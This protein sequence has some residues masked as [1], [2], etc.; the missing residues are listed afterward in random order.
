M[1]TCSKE[2]F[3]K[4]S[5]NSFRRLT[6]VE[7][8]REVKLTQKNFI[9]IPDVV[10]RKTGTSTK[11]EMLYIY[12]LILKHKNCNMEIVNTPILYISNYNIIKL[13]K[14]LIGKSKSTLRGYLKMTRVMIEHLRIKESSILTVEA[15]KIPKKSDPL[16]SYMLIIY[17]DEN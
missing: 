4:L 10:S 2:D 8:S 7:T 16:P 15:H 9:E 11:C 3:D 5:S 14:Q 12:A 6:T 1:E 13:E 17:N